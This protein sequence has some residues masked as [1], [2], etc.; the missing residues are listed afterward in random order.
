MVSLL[1]QL[2]GLALPKDAHPHGEVRMPI[3][4]EGAAVGHV[5][6]STVSQGDPG[7]LA[8]VV[9]YRIPTI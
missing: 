2:A 7:N 3:E 1:V 6:G 4:V 5:F 8:G 9:R